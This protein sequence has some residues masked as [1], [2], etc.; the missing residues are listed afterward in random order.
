MDPSFPPLNNIILVDSV[1]DD[2]I[3]VVGLVVRRVEVDVVVMYGLSTEDF[4]FAAVVVVV[5]VGIAKDIV[6]VDDDDDDDDEGV[7]DNIFSPI[8]RL[9]SMGLTRRAAIHQICDE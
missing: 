9:P 1:Y 6:V 4:S 7:D 8:C 2:I 5:V 3:R